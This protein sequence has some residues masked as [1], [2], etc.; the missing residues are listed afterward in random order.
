MSNASDA[1]RIWGEV[2]ADQLDALLAAHHI[3]ARVDRTP[4]LRPDNDEHNDEEHA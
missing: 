2:I 3:P 1:Q 4:I